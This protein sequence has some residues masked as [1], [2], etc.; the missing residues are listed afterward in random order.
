MALAINLPMNLHSIYNKIS[1]RVAL[2]ITLLIVVLLVGI[3]FLVVRRG[4][5]AFNDVYHIFVGQVERSPNQVP[6][7]EPWY[8]QGFS[9]GGP[10]V[11]T[12]LTPREHFR[13][14]FQSSLIVI[15]LAALACA[16]GIGFLISRTIAKPLNKLS[17]GLKK[18]RQSHYQLRLDEEKNSEE[19]NT[20]VQ[21][22]NS[23]AAE[24]QRV[25]EL[26]KNLISDASHEFRTPL[27]SL[28]A[29]LEGVQDGVLKMDPERLAILQNQVA[30]LHEL[31][32]GLQD[33]AYYRSQAIKIEKKPVILGSLVSNIIKTHDQPLAEKKIYVKS[34]VPEN[35]TIDADPVLLER[36]FN[37]LTENAIRYSQAS[38]IT[39]RATEKEISFSDN[40]VG[41]PPEHLQNIFERFFR[42][43]KSRSRSTGG[44]GLGLSITKE[45]VE[46]HGWHIHA[47]SPAN[48][49]GINFIINLT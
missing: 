37:N 18:L 47:E 36:I 26:R 27:A 24:L 17:D 33:Y 11:G 2:I 38:Q 32:N 3:N 1:F 46:A 42:L 49:H 21:E 20:I 4:E 23:L 14:R 43:D 9:I 44:M 48:D 10:P 25:E 39:V 35:L 5:N 40:G 7:I 34:D 15:G 41:I 45:I 8:G 29:Q 16:A 13:V 22:F 30:R 6:L 19:F 12:E 31:T 28:Q